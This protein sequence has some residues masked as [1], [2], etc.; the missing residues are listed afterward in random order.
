MV[1]LGLGWQLGR[2]ARVG[3]AAPQH[4]RGDEPG[5][6]AGLLLV[7]ARLDRRGPDLAEGVAAAEQPRDRPVEDGPELGEVVLDGRA[8]QRDAGGAG[9]GTQRTGGSRRGVLDVLCLVGD[10]QPPRHVA[11]ARPGR[12]GPV[13]G[14]EGAV[15]GQHEAVVHAGERPAA[16]VE[17][18]HGSA[19][20]EPLDLG[21]PV[22]EQGRRADDQGGP[23]LLARLMACLEPPKVKSDQLDG[24]A[25]PH[26]VGQAAA[27][28]ERGELVEPG[29]AVPLVVA[30]GGA[31]GGRRRDRLAGGRAE[32]PLTDL[33]QAGA[34][35]DL[36][37]TV[38]DLDGAGECGRDGLHRGDRADQPLLGLARDG[39]VDDRPGT[40]QLQ[41]R[42]GRARELAHLVVTEGLAVERD[43]PLEGE[44][45]VGTE[46]AGHQRV[47][48]APA[49]PV[50]VVLE[51]GPRRQ[52]AAEAARP[53][54][55]DPG[56]AERGDPLVEQRHQLV[57]VEGD[58]VGHA[59]LQQPVEDRPRL[60]RRTQRDRRVGAGPLAETV[61]VG[62]PGPQQGRVAQ[63]ERVELV[64]DLE[65]QAHRAGEQLLLVGLDAQRD[66]DQGGQAGR[67]TDGRPRS[68][69][70]GVEAPPERL[71]LRRL[72]WACP[73]AGRRRRPRPGRAR[74]TPPPRPATRRTTPRPPACAPARPRRGRAPT[75]A[76]A[77]RRART[78]RRRPGG[79]PAPRPRR[80]ARPWGAGGRAR[81]A[82]ASTGSASRT[83]S[84]TVVVPS[85]NS[86]DESRGG[87]AARTVAGPDTGTPDELT[88]GL[89]PPTV[90]GPGDTG[91]ARH[92]GLRPG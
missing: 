28:A 63:V 75:A 46:Q 74:R 54:H 56:T 11:Q 78:G 88:G 25:Q 32:Q 4:E 67:A 79:A 13:V 2:D 39:W 15:G 66:G 31:E 19:G 91:D 43:L 84:E 58:L 17:A 20:R 6:L 9:N 1:G 12:V 18:T 77:R 87:S 50:V 22:A 7:D 44:H 27:Q 71:P 68:D 29:Q 33:Q 76:S 64:V 53:Q 70:L 23:G 83:G 3:L 59:Q 45:R 36:L 37:L 24:L 61:V 57:G 52:V 65:H 82:R 49:R 8:G 38:V 5:E 40:A 51:G 41:H 10:D 47:V 26:V 89:T 92:P 55:V 86:T 73:G 69:Q 35:H 16:A 21:L 60:G 34:D 42:A 62:T 81:R 85:E 72:G 30:Q 90:T 14:P 48:L 80:A